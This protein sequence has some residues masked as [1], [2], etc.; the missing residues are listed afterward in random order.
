MD[1]NI[2]LLYCIFGSIV[3]AMLILPFIHNELNSIRYI[4]FSL[5]KITDSISIVGI[6]LTIIFAI[7]LIIENFPTRGKK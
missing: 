3:L 7:M 4:G 2:K 5:V 6:V 1:K